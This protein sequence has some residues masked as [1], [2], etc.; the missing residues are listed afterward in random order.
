MKTKIRIL[1]CLTIHM[2]QPNEIRDYWKR[3]RKDHS[4]W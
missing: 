2:R 3:K 4:W 1:I